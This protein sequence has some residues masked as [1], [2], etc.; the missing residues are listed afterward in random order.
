MTVVV[1]VVGSSAVAVA[2]AIAVAVS[3][4]LVAAM[5]IC[6]FCCCR[7]HFVFVVAAMDIDIA[8]VDVAELAT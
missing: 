5:D 8:A 1:I 7:G 3:L 6:F 2:N 4:S